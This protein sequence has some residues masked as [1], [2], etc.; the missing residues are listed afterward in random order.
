VRIVRF[1]RAQDAKV[2]MREMQVD[3]YGIEIMAPKALMVVLRVDALSPVCANILKQEMLSLGGDCAI[4]RHAL[5]VRRKKTDSLVFGTLAQVRRLSVKLR[6]QPF[7]LGLIGERIRES[8]DNY[9][10][11]TFT[12]DL[13]GRRVR[14]GEK[15]LIMGI[16]NLTPD[17][18]SGDGLC[19]SKDAGRRTKVDIGE[20][21]AYVERMIADGA[22][23]ID[24][25]G[26][27]SR[28]G[29]RPVGLSAETARV[30]PVIKACAKRVRVPISV[31]T[32]K[33]EVARRALD[34]GALIVNDI[35][36]L[37]DV[38]M[39]RVVASCRAG[40]VIMHML[41]N[42]RTMQKDPSYLSVTGDIIAYLGKAMD[43]A[44]EAGISREGVILDPGI[45]FGKT[46]AQNLTI[47]NNLSE[48]KVLGRPLLVGPSRKSFL[49]AILN[50]G[51]SER[52]LGTAATCVIAAMNGARIMR[53]HD[54]KA[55]RQALAVC[56][57]TRK[58]VN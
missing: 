19:R 16:V 5:T 6:K 12:L 3:P 31:D 29:A 45:G 24:I 36:G 47:L 55:V 41:G 1:S 37:R 27:S 23:M 4:A 54:V 21:L 2:L 14:L 18:F 57:A 38:R 33:P 9:A 52:S 39:A 8:V 58:S 48:F 17:S 20:I 30:I 11:D 25:G 13:G 15:T 53:V 44:A 22:D 34:N 28:P 42:P 43:R 26:E 50:A 7:G 56:D 40:V 10:L 49:G 35:C 51:L 32:S 46:V